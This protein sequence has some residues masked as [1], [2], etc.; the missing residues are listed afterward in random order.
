VCVRL[1]DGE[2]LSGRRLLSRV[3]LRSQQ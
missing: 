3:F 1:S 2:E